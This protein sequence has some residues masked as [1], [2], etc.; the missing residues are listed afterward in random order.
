[1]KA[2]EQRVMKPSLIAK[3]TGALGNN[4]SDTDMLNNN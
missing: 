4:E 2:V 1:M 3:W